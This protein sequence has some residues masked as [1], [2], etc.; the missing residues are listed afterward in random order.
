MSAPSSMNGNG[1]R[2][3]LVDA[4]IYIFRAWHSL[5]DTIRDSRGQ[6]A[7]AVHGF[8]DFAL[9]LL[10]QVKPQQIVFT[11]D[12]SLEHSYRNTIYPPYKAHREPAPDELKAQFLHCRELLTA[13]GIS[14][15]AS[16]YYEA[17]DLIGTLSQ[18]AH[19]CRQSVVI[20]S[21]D[22]DLAQLVEEGDLWWDYSQNIQLDQQ[23]IVNKFGVLPQQIADVLAIAGDPVD[24]IPGVPGI[25]PK[26]AAKLIHHFGC[27]ERLLSEVGLIAELD[28]RGAGRIEGLVREYKETIRM[29]HRLTTIRR[30]VDL[31]EDFTTHISPSDGERTNALF[32]HLGFSVYRRRRWDDCLAALS[33]T[34]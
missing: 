13:L 19:Q 25:G 34:A 9:R 1:A 4:S 8:C 3:Y 31:P 7:N 15:I 24:N 6:A 21:C 33:A 32:K 17:D 28:M 18:R 30:D 2:L 5:P 22:K 20:V 27:I 14:E 12:E 26:T 29:A 10:A 16:G 23:G 11:F